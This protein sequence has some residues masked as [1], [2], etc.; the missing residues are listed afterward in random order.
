M[1]MNGPFADDFWKMRVL[2]STWA[3]KIKRFP[4][5]AVKKFKACFCAC[6]NRQ[7]HGVNNRET[8][9]PVVNWSTICT[10]MILAAKER[11][12]S[13]QCDITAAFVTAPIPPDEVVYVAQPCGFVQGTNKVLCLKTCLYGMR[14]S[15]RYFF[16]YLTEKLQKQGLES[17][18][19]VPCLFL[20]KDILAIIYVDD[21][22]LYG[23][24]EEAIDELITNLK[25]DDVRLRK[26][27]T[28]KGYLGLK[29]ERDRNKPILSQP[30][31][32]KRVIE[33][34]S[35]SSKFSPTVSTPAEQ[36]ALPRDI[37]GKSA[38]G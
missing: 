5:G 29:L 17:S 35:L 38:T 4:D 19:L 34:L 28:A 26:E 14:Q 24:S 37:D 32:I 20:G 1:A 25:N 8:W 36:A 10:I 12:V 22:L 11:L 6:G 15:R 16:Q 9:S 2:P 7:E 23:R 30:G 27:G 33:G 3:F 31:L 21:V 18:D 13:A